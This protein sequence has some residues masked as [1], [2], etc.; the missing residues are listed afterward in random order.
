[1][2]VATIL[3]EERKRIRKN[4]NFNNLFIKKEMLFLG[5]ELIL[6]AMLKISKSSFI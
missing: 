1:M 4:A 6:I 5:F 3:K 2:W